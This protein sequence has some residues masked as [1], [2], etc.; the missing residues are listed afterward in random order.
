MNWVHGASLVNFYNLS[1]Q[2]ILEA[3]VENSEWVH[4][5]TEI[6]SRNR[7]YAFSGAHIYPEIGFSVTLQR[8]PTYYMYNIII[9]VVLLTFLSGLVFVMP[10]E[11]GE[12][13]GLQISVLLAFYLMLLVM[14][15]STPKSGKSTTLI[16]T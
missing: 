8:V 13:V 9:P 16:S 1:D 5:K 11:A 6:R 2:V 14:G 4:L 7:T 10:V 3:F 15:D 12:K